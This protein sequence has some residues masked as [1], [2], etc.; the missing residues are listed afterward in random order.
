M[1]GEWK[2]T[3]ARIMLDS[4][5]IPLRD[6]KKIQVQSERAAPYRKGRRGE[7]IGESKN[8]SSKMRENQWR[9]IFP[10]SASV[11]IRERRHFG[12][13]ASEW[14]CLG[15]AARLLFCEGAC[16]VLTRATLSSGS[17]FLPESRQG[18]D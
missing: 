15:F 12:V 14:I 4:L 10:N 11:R 6:S 13:A 17:V 3:S 7:W 5:Q 8:K 1:P 18:V 9:L 16:T 2:K